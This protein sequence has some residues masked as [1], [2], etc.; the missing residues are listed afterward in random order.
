MFA[1]LYPGLLQRQDGAN[2][3]RKQTLKVLAKFEAGVR[4]H[5]RC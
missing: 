2:H 3:L 4:E 1:N 5:L